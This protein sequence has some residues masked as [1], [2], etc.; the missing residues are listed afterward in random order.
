MCLPVPSL[1]DE[2][3]AELDLNLTQSH[4]G[5][6]SES[7]SRGRRSLGKTE[8]E[9]G[10]ASKVGAPGG[11]LGCTAARG[12]EGGPRLFHTQGWVELRENN[13]LK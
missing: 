6:K 1:A 10:G 13:T 12:C 7:L 5:G 11:E 9:N 2:D 8:G 4:S 3:G